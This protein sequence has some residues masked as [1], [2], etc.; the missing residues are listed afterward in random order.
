MPAAENVR[1]KVSAARR[2]IFFI[3]VAFPEHD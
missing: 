1:S 2:M 3:V